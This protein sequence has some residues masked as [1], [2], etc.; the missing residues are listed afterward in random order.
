[1]KNNE[2]LYNKTI[3]AALRLSFIALL[4]VWSFLIIKPFIMP[5]LWG[6]IIAVVLYPLHKRVTAWLGG[7]EKASAWVITLVLLALLVIPSWIFLGSAVEGIQTFAHRI[8]EG[9]LVIPPPQEKVAHWPVVGKPIYQAW[10]A[11]A[12]NTDE[13]LQRYHEQLRTVATKLLQSSAGL[14]ITL[15]LFILSVIIAGVLLPISQTGRRAADK[16]FDTLLGDYGDDFVQLS[17]DIIRSVVQGI[18]LVA[19]I[20]SVLLG[21][22]M[23]VA[24]IPAAGLWALIVLLLAIMQLPPW[25]VM[26]PL[27][28]YGFSIMDTTWA[29]IFLIYSMAISMSDPFLKAL[30]L[31]RGVAIP[32]LVVLLGAIGGMLLSGIIGLF[33]GAVVL[34][35]TYKVFV[36]LVA[37]SPEET[38]GTE[39]PTLQE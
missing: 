13:A 5:V 11:F 37:K 38:A 16:V 25:L 32:T 30:F 28:I 8:N 33:V 9:T 21:L 15:L 20:Q 34:A 14:V 39:N 6:I 17:A 26:L 18:L 3:I 10:E 29:V 1:M 7:R 27:A 23:M 2:E 12:T 24:G 31:G 36:A 4:I 19:A 35:I 22:G